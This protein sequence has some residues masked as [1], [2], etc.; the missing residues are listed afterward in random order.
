MPFLISSLVLSLALWYTGRLLMTKKNQAALSLYGIHLSLLFLT[1]L[2]VTD[3]YL[4]MVP[5][6]QM[7]SL[8]L[9]LTYTPII[10]WRLGMMSGRIWTFI[11]LLCLNQFWCVVILMKLYLWKKRE[12]IAIYPLLY[13]SF[14]SLSTQILFWIFPSKVENILSANQLLQ[15]LKTR[16]FSNQIGY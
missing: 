4:S 16:F 11:I 15:A 14:R 6:L 5:L 10:L 2:R 13:E 1:I 3:R 9:L 12:I 7:T 8:V